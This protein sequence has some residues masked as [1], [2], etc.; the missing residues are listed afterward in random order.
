MLSKFDFTI[1]IVSAIVS[2][3]LCR[4]VI[5]WATRFK[6]YA[7]EG[8]RTLHAGSVPRAGG[9]AIVLTVIAGQAV[10][11]F[12][13]SSVMVDPGK[14]WVCFAIAV[15]ILGFIDDV[16]D[17][18]AIPRLVIQIFL[19]SG[20]VATCVADIDLIY[21]VSFWVFVTLVVWGINA[22]NFMDGADGMLGIQS[23]LIAVS[24]VLFL[25][26]LGDGFTELTLL[27]LCGACL[28]FLFWNWGGAKLFLG[29]TGSYFI[30]FMLVAPPIVVLKDLRDLLA[31][32][33][34]YLPLYLDA[35]F[36]L[37]RRLINRQRIWEPHREHLYQLMIRSG[38]THAHTSAIYG[39]I[40]VLGMIPCA[41]LAQIYPTVAIPLFISMCVI[42]FAGW[43]CGVRYFSAKVKY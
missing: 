29:D 5:S 39:G 8:S 40:L 10:W 38:L 31:V 14:V 9:T 12:N 41:Y 26:T 13:N 33:L 1:I 36:T 32:G 4:L 11:L 43:Y 30:G 21:S 3:F 28:G 42:V 16:R 17:L 35:A 18:P 24:L 25:P 37:L 22:A 2:G 7:R 27:C 15:S 23:M 34:L 6:V 19:S 20:L